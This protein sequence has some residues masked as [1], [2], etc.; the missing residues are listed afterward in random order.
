[1]GQKPHR[2]A[3]ATWIALAATLLLGLAAITPASAA[4]G[5][6][7]KSRLRVEAECL[8]ASQLLHLNVQWSNFTPPS[9]VDLVITLTFKRPTVERQFTVFAPVSGTGN[10]LRLESLPEGFASWDDVEAVNVRATGAFDAVSKEAARQPR[11]G[12]NTNCP[13]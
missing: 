10:E 11:A 12:W 9:D 4:P 5:G 1:M 3:R 7:Q 13:T 8:D 2:L 6:Q